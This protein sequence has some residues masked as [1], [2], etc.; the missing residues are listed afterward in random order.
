MTAE[1]KEQDSQWFDENQQLIDLEL[2]KELKEAQLNGKLAKL[3]IPFPTLTINTNVPNKSYDRRR[4]VSSAYSYTGTPTTTA[5]STN[6]NVVSAAAAAAAVAT[7]NTNAASAAFSGTSPMLYNND[8]N[9]DNNN[10][11]A[12]IAT[13]SRESNVSA[14]KMVSRDGGGY[15]LIRTNSLY[16]QSFTS[17]AAA[18][19]SIGYHAS[20][21][22]AVKL[23]ATAGNSSGGGAGA[24]V[25]ASGS[26]SGTWES[27]YAAGRESRV[28]SMAAA[29]A[30]AA[31]TSDAE[32]CGTKSIVAGGSL[33]DSV[34]R[35]VYSN[36]QWKV[37]SKLENEEL[38]GVAT[39]GAIESRSHFETPD[40]TVLRMPRNRSSS[41]QTPSD[42]R[43]AVS[44]SS[45]SR[46][47][48]APTTVAGGARLL[49]E[50]ST[51]VAVPKAPPLQAHV[52]SQLT[53]SS[54]NVLAPMRFRVLIGVFI[55]LYSGFI[56]SYSGWV[57]SYSLLMGLT[58]SPGTAATITS[59]YYSW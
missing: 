50:A 9:N 18:V 7:S 25:G 37:R 41:F 47:Y 44:P 22:A 59:T 2:E 46:F 48:A 58:K 26:E 35:A 19:A 11:S 3:Q 31:T 56:H 24:S 34:D 52:K 42:V 1:T 40:S 15:N 36:S 20:I 55:F 4:S 13:D 49:V 39:I 27:P 43:F 8:N 57:S 14:D 16:S 53:G 6:T 10:N 33:I 51:P 38:S 29:A 23:A 32:E 45:G 28:N 17:S 12:D 54:S 21:T 30:T 5:A